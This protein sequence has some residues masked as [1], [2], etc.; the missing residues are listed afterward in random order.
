MLSS[1]KSA[2]FTWGLKTSPWTKTLLVTQS[3]L[4]G[5]PKLWLEARPQKEGVGQS[6]GRSRQDTTRLAAQMPRHSPSHVFSSLFFLF[7]SR[8]GT[9][10]A[11][12]ALKPGQ[13]NKRDLSGAGS[14]AKFLQSVRLGQPWPLYCS[15]TGHSRQHCLPAALPGLSG[16]KTLLTCGNA[17]VTRAS[18]SPSI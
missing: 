18:V 2:A 5:G 11:I 12:V 16:S 7:L 6:P 9:V 4:Q 15:L 8:P 13:A 17:K 14:E 1:P 3:Q 10:D